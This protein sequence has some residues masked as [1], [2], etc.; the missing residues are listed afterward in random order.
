MS[1]EVHK[2]VEA[3]KM[4]SHPEGGFYKETYRSSGVVPKEVLGGDFSG[5]RNYSTAIY[6]LLTSDNFSAFHKIKQDEIWHH[7][8]GASLDIHV[9][10]PE[11]VYT[12]YCLGVNLEKGEYPQVVVPAGCWFASGVADA[13]GYSL[14]GCTVSPGFDFDDFVLAERALLIAQFPEYKNV[15]TQFTRV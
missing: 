1:E 4:K 12:K 8:Q 10:D 9:I 11:G 15:I 13:Q 3:L 14:V 6:F 2:I 7:Y 5:V